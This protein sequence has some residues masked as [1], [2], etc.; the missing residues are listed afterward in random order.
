MK[1]CDKVFYKMSTFDIGRSGTV[2]HG[3]SSNLTNKPMGKL[4]PEPCMIH[5]HL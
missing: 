4:S 1:Y 2:F 5:P 3:I